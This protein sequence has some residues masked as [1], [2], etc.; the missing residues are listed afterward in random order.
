MRK[1]FNVEWNVYNTYTSM[2]NGNICY[3]MFSSKPNSTKPTTVSNGLLKLKMFL[4]SQVINLLHSLLWYKISL[5]FIFQAICIL[6][7]TAYINCG[8]FENR[9]CNNPTLQSELCFIFVISWGIILFEN[10]YFLEHSNIWKL[11]CNI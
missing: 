6:T 8:T 11:A 4:W 2:S 7:H 5:T 3:R 9:F 1:L 10:I